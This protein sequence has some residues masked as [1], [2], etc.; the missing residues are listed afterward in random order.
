VVARGKTEGRAHMTK[1]V[2]TAAYA[3]ASRK[4]AL[5]YTAVRIARLFK[6]KLSL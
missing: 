1:A 6:V 4:G 5:N 3:N 2:D